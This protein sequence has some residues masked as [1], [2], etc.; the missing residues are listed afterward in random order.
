MLSLARADP[1]LCLRGLELRA[2]LST[3]AKRGLLESWM[4]EKLVAQ[5]L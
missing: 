3:Q 1:K 4:V 2:Q 5:V